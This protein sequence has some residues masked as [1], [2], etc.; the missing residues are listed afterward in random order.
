MFITKKK[1]LLTCLLLV[2]V[3][4]TTTAYAQKGLKQSRADQILQLATAKLQAIHTVHYKLIRESLYKD[5]NYH[6]I[7]SSDIYIDFTSKKNTAGYRF[8]AEDKDYQS[9]YNGVQYFGLNKNKKTIDI[10]QKPKAE[11]FESMSP[12]YFSLVS[13][14]TILPILQKNDSVEVVM[15]DTVIGKEDY[16]SFSFDLYNQYFGGLGKLYQLTSDYT[17]DRTKPYVLIIHKKTLLPY[18]FISKWKDRTED[19]ISVTYDAIN[20]KPSAPVELSWFYSTY[21]NEYAPP[22]PKDPLVNVGTV[23]EDWVLPWYNAGKI[24]SSSLYQYRGKIVLLDFWIKSCGPCMASFPHLNELQQKFNSNEFQLLSINTEDEQEDIVFFF[25][26]HKPIYKMLF[27]GENLA[28]AY[29]IPAFPTIILLDKLGK[30]I[31][32]SKNGFDQPVIEKLIKENL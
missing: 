14:R 23:L 15:K 32:A 6:A 4:A 27:K 11:Q 2:L 10:T 19:F 29:G 17:G 20:L 13:L 3:C 9:C 30:V 26:K 16:Y 24:D 18:K 5:E 28:S 25:N 8:Q 21:T 7:Y 22:Q 1:I 12:L 31:Y